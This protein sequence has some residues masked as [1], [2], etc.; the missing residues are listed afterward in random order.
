MSIVS[1]H[2]ISVCHLLTDTVT[3]IICIFFV[4][5]SIWNTALDHEKSQFSL[6]IWVYSF[7]FLDML[8]ELPLP[9]PQDLLLYHDAPD[10]CPLCDILTHYLTD[11]HLKCNSV[12]SI[13]FLIPI[14]MLV[15]RIK[16]KLLIYL[17][18]IFRSLRQWKPYSKMYYLP[19]RGGI[20]I[21]IGSMVLRFKSN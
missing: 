21:R 2:I 6:Y 14:L 3:R 17:F 20:N 9:H 16:F 8:H 19:I 10:S 7:T 4:A 5:W 13:Y 12:L 11:H 15:L 18:F 1:G